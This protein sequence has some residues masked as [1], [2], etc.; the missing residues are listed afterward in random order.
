LSISVFFISCIIFMFLWHYLVGIFGKKKCW[1]AYSLI[2]VLTFSLFLMCEE[3]SLGTL[4]FCSIFC[5]LPAGGT[6]LN[7]VFV[8]DVIDYDEFITGK[9]NEGLYT[10]F[11]S[12]IPKIT[13]IFAQSVPLTILSCKF[14]LLIKI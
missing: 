9:R 6:Y 4:V 1:E 7:D 8:S 2:S 11:A 14:G 5:A 12:F 10:V 13:S 3:G